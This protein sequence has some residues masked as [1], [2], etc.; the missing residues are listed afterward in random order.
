M[1]RKFKYYFK[2][3]NIHQLHKINEIDSIFALLDQKQ[4]K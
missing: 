1:C 3:I 2:K 4:E